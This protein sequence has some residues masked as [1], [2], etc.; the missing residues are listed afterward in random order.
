M[1]CFGLELEIRLAE[2]KE[3]LLFSSLEKIFIE[4]RIY[5]D[6]EECETWEEV[7]ETIDRGLDPFKPQFYREITQEDIVRLT[8]IR[9]KR[10]SKFNSFKADEQI[11]S[12]EEEITEIEHHLAHLTEF[13]IDY[14]EDLIKRF[15]AGRERK[16]IIGTFRQ[17][18]GHAA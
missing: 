8:E 13:A 12:L 14:F 17:Y 10:I 2:L 7:L 5:R 11:R 4:N 9:I 16:T 15:G 6:I 1:S 18:P 3:K